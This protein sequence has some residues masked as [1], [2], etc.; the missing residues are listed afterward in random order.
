[1]FFFCPFEEERKKWVSKNGKINVIYYYGSFSWSKKQK[2]AL[3]LI[4][5]ILVR[6]FLCRWGLSNLLLLFFVSN[7]FTIF[8]SLLIVL[9]LRH[10]SPLI[11]K[12]WRVEIRRN[13]LN[14]TCVCS[15]YFVWVIMGDNWL[16]KSREQCLSE[17]FLV[18]IWF[19][20]CRF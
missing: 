20:F 12:W 17:A 9:Y 2:Y 5:E 13:K 6:F 11:E 16:F 14:W 15:F 19:T 7:L 10:N 1:M 8:P 18:S 3:K 4:N